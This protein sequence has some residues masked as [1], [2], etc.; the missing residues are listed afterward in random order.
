MWQTT[1]VILILGI[2]L[3]AIGGMRGT[4]LGGAILFLGLPL[5]ALEYLFPTMPV[6]IAFFIVVAFDLLLLG[7]FWNRLFPKEE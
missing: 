5:M 6:H 4:L 3:L 7:V 1:L 2:V